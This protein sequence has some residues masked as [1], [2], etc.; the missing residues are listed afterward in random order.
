MKKIKITS[1]PFVAVLLLLEA[2]ISYPCLAQDEQA[3]VH[4]PTRQELC[5]LI[6]NK[7]AGHL[8]SSYEDKAAELER[9]YPMATVRQTGWYIASPDGSSIEQTQ[10]L[11][12][13][14]DKF[15]EGI[16][17]YDY[18]DNTVR[19]D[20]VT[21]Q[22]Y[23]TKT[24]YYSSDASCNDFVGR[25]GL[26]ISTV[27]NDSAFPAGTPKKVILL[28]NAMPE[29]HQPWAALLPESLK[30]P[31]NGIQFYGPLYLYQDEYEETKVIVY[32]PYS[33]GAHSAFKAQN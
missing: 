5:D 15:V 1:A 31:N 11:W 17:G 3:Y 19:A 7:I 30:S 33:F 21:G 27:E 23:Y 10:S 24:H 26:A 20:P 28:D 18:T 2:L 14:V 22:L 13:Q 29:D 16:Y 32:S 9:N 12:D 6:N 4:D 8:D 25:W